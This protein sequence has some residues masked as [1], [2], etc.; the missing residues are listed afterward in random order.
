MSNISFDIPKINWAKAK[1][2]GAGISA[3]VYRIAPGVVIRLSDL[4]SEATVIRQSYMAERGLALPVLAYDLS[5]RPAYRIRRQF[6]PHHRTYR[7]PANFGGC[8][9]E[10]GLSAI[11]M[12]EAET[13]GDSYN[14]ED[15]SD[16]VVWEFIRY[17]KDYCKRELNYEW[18]GHDGNVALWN[19]GY[20]ALDF[21]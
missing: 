16:P 20:V 11:V 7:E 18:D 8:Y 13:T 5:F 19:G 2:L 15:N 6:C 10:S 1:F 3:R 17:I 4:Q 12:P 14:W 9:C 21:D